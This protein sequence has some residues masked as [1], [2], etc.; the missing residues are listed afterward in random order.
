M[1]CNYPRKNFAKYFYN[2]IKNGKH[3]AT[4]FKD[5]EQEIYAIYMSKNRLYYYEGCPVLKVIDINTLEKQ[6]PEFVWK[7][8]EQTLKEL[9]VA[10]DF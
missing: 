5:K 8:F 4:F 1:Y 6:E 9:D 7:L 3:Y 2:T 10:E